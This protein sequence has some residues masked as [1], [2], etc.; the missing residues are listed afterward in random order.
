MQ[1]QKIVLPREIFGSLSDEMNIRAFA[2]RMGLLG[3]ATWA[4]T[5]LGGTTLASW[6]VIPGNVPVAPGDDTYTC[7]PPP[8]AYRVNAVAAI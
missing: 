2:S 6:D 4:G 3:R 7:S 5:D 1:N 8:V